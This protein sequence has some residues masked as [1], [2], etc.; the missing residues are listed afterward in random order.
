MKKKVS[1]SESK[2][3]GEEFGIVGFVLGLLSIVLVG[4]NGI[5]LAILG[6]IFSTI[7]QKRKPT[8]LARIGKILSIVGIILAVILIIVLIIVAPSLG[9]FPIN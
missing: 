6:L 2:G 4:S 7:Q 9:D 3:S 5:I 8:K 1:R